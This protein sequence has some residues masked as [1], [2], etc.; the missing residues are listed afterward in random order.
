MPSPKMLEQELRRLATLDSVSDY[1]KARLIEAADKIA[2]LCAAIT[3][4]ALSETPGSVACPGP[5]V[6][7]RLFCQPTILCRM[8][9]GHAVYNAQR[10][11]ACPM[12]Y[13]PR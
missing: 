5:G 2:E 11:D 1:V 10:C 12:R 9:N 13:S 3:Q 8:P 7:R 4:M 6:V